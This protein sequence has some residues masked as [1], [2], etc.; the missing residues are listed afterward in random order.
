MKESSMKQMRQQLAD[1]LE[2]VAELSK[3]VTGAVQRIRDL[4]NLV[5]RYAAMSSANSMLMTIPENCQ[6]ICKIRNA[7][8]LEL[9]CV[10]NNLCKTE[11]VSSK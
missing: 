11:K 8:Y 4:E 1:A 6:L 7:D 3:T 2:E 9:S 5:E 10:L